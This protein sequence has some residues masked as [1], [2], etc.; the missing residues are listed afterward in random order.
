MKDI[1]DLFGQTHSNLVRDIL[2]RGG[3]V[4][5]MKVENFAGVL[6]KNEA[7]ALEI[8][9]RLEETTGIKGYISTDELPRYGI[10]AGEK[11]AIEKAFG[12]K[13]KDVV[14]LIAEEKKKA[15][16]ALKIVEEEIAKHKTKE[17]G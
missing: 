15:R 3:V 2:N 16:K 8:E 10:L 7:L 5:G 13:K 9:R 14:I 12:V 1:S 6:L 11:E 4:L 17:Q